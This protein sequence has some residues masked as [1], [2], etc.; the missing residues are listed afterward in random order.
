MSHVQ[1]VGQI[2]NT[3]FLKKEGINNRNS[4]Y[5]THSW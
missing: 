1:E 3:F 4:K 2:E 5:R